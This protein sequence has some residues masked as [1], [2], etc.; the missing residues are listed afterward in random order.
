M[1]RAIGCVLRRS[2]GSR[3]H[4]RPRHIPGLCPHPCHSRVTHSRNQADI[5]GHR[6]TRRRSSSGTGGTLQTPQDTRGHGVAPVR[7]REAPG[8]NPGPPTNFLF[9]IADFARSVESPDYSHVTRLPA[10]RARHL[11]SVVCR[12]PILA[13][14]HRHLSRPLFVDPRFQG[15]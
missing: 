5:G 14:I 4:S 1:S 9:K 7:D 8:S 12:Q 2:Q 10:T 13:N 11:R 15:T 3:D 6:R